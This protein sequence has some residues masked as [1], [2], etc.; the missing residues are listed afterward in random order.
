MNK[1]NSY[2]GFAIKSKKVVYGA[3]NI[4]KSKACKLIVASQKLSS[5]TLE[6]L[7]T[8]NTQIII[9]PQADY[10]QLNLKGLVVAITDK[11]LA[12]AIQNNL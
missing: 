8:K 1:I 2:I 12:D 5:N 6:K 10:S 9:L 11:S 4:L 3:D 7:N